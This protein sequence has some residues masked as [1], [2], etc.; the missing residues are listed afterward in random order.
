MSRVR[1]RSAAPAMVFLL[2]TASAGAHHSM[3]EFDKQKVVTLRGVITS[4]K[5]ENPHVWV[6]V[7]VKDE[8][9]KIV[10]W[11][12][13][14]S[15]P[16]ALVRHGM[17]ASMLK[18]GIEVTVKTNPAVDTSRHLGFLDEM[19]FPGGYTYRSETNIGRGPS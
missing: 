5:W 17:N 7:D 4:V 8:T 12:F 13:E 2:V 15:G 16:A 14:G 6:Y 1:L 18:P 3:A 10:N 19:T 11:G 9:G